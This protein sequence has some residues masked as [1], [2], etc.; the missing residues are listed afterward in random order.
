RF[1]L[2]RLYDWLNTPDGALVT[3]KDPI[4]YLRRLNFHLTARDE[5]AYGF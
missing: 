4:E 1:L 3:R 2:T 5:R